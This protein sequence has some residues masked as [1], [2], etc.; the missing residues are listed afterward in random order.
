M[1]RGGFTI[2][3]QVPL[4]CSASSSSFIVCFHLA[5]RGSRIAS[6]MLRVFNHSHV[7]DIGRYVLS[8]HIARPHA[9]R[10]LSL[11]SY[12]IATTRK[13]SYSCHGSTL[14]LVLPVS[15]LF[16]LLLP[17]FSFLLLIGLSIATGFVSLC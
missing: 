2:T 3:S 4:L 10:D 13:F 15:T 5:A 14:H 7:S 6:I 16:F 8:A 12:W 1:A 9:G 11:T 17:F